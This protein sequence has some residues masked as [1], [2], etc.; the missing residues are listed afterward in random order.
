MGRVVVLVCCVLAATT[1]SH[2]I[3][4]TA[5]VTSLAKSVLEVETPYGV[6]VSP[7]FV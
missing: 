1:H 3:F 2:S 4:Q 6:I 7:Q 5:N